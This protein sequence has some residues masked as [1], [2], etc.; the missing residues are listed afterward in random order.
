MRERYGR[1]PAVAPPPVPLAY[2]P[3]VRLSTDLSR[4]PNFGGN[5][6]KLLSDYDETPEQL[7]TDLDAARKTNT[8]NN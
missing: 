2:Q 1:M 4:L 6:V 7:T 3:S 5:A 8:V